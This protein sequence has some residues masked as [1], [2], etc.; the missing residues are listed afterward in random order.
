MATRMN[1]SQKALTIHLYR[2]DE[3]LACF[4]YAILNRNPREAL[5]WGLELF[6]SDYEKDLFQMLG[7]IWFSQIGLGGWGVFQATWAMWDSGE[8]D[9]DELQKLLVAWCRVESHDASAFVLLVRGCLESASWKPNFPHTKPYT[10][11][12]DAMIDCLRRGKALEAWL[13][14]RGLPPVTQW[15]LLQREKPSK[16]LDL[17]ITCS[18]GS[19]IERRAIAF[20][21]SCG[22]QDLDSVIFATKDLPIELQSLVAEWDAEENLRKRRFYPIRMEALGWFTARGMLPTTDSIEDDL[23]WGLEGALW[24]SPYWRTILESYHASFHEPSNRLIWHDNCKEAFYHT[25]FPWTKYDIPDEWS[26]ADRQKS[27]HRGLG[28][29]AAAARILMLQH[30]LRSCKTA[31]L[32]NGLQGLKADAIPDYDFES[33]YTKLQ[34]A[35]ATGIPWPLPPI[36][37]AFEII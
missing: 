36:S 5:F 3:V 22:Q 2:V 17:V 26:A 32:W 14:A 1:N 16:A 29:S 7:V 33:E 24:F 19:E 27:H 4:R 13:L 37:L 12:E 20:V 30:L 11:A 18:F 8:L 10:S 15:E 9:R 21:I 31:A 35:C 34:G 25:Y 23:C 28:K 6:D